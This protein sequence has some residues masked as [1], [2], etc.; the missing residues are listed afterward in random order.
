LSTITEPVYGVFLTY[1]YNAAGLLETVTDPLG[2]QAR[3]TYDDQQNLIKISD[4][5]GQTTTYTYDKLGQTLTGTNAEGMLLFRY[6]Y[7]KDRRI[8]EQSDA[9]GTEWLY[10]W[11]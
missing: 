8:I 7:D 11:P 3:L 10:R 9:N 1:V 2:R 4:A 5:A 6:T